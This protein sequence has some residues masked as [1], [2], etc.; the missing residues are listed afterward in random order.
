VEE[1]EITDI[2]VKSYSLSFN[3]KSLCLE[4]TPDTYVPD[5]LITNIETTIPVTFGI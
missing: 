5:S 2:K 3:A 4:Q 1:C